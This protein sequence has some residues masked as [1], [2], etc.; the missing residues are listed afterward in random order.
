MRLG[1]GNDIRI[2]TTV[3]VNVFVFSGVFNSGNM[4][5]FLLAAVTVIVAI[6]IA[7]K[8]ESEAGSF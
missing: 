1:G 2:Y 4:R 6:I 7:K 5:P 8:I 3:I